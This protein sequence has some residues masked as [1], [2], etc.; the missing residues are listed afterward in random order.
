MTFISS[1]RKFVCC[2]EQICASLREN[3]TSGTSNTQ[4]YNQLAMLLGL[5]K[6][7]T[8]LRS[9]KSYNT[10]KVEGKNGADYNVHVACA[11]APSDKRL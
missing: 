11:D 9:M 1:S 2:L 10:I 6:S 5:V 3:I 8:E 7:L 4:G